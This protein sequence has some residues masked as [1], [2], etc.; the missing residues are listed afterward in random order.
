MPPD[1][2]PNRP[3]V[4]AGRTDRGEGC[5][6]LLQAI[7]FAHLGYPHRTARHSS[8]SFSGLLPACLQ[9]AIEL[10]ETGFENAG[11]AQAAALGSCRTAVQRVEITARPESRLELVGRIPR[12]PDQAALGEDDAPG[13]Q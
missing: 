10:A 12:A 3:D 11:H 13:H 8:M 1:P 4:R 2:S 6:T 9:R 5:E 7:H